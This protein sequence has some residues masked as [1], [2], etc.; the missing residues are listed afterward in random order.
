MSV[1]QIETYNKCPFL[2]FIQYSLGIYPLK[3]DKLMSNE[4]GSLVHYVL[5]INIKQN[6]NIGQLVDYYISRDEST[7]SKVSKEYPGKYKE[8][9]SAYSG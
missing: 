7:F 2:Y 3:E 4:L 5:S 8:K 6:R 9:K 1:S